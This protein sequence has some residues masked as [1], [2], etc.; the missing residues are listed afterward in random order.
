MFNTISN[1]NR[2]ADKLGNVHFIS[3]LGSVLSRLAYQDDNKFLTNYSKII[4]PI[5]Q[6]KIL[7]GINNVSSTNLSQLLD[8]Q[9]IFKLDKSSNDI[10]SNYE[11][12]FNGK[13]Y[14][15][16]IK[17][18]MPQNV[19]ITNGDISGIMNFPIP[20]EPTAP[21]IVKYISIG[22]SNYGEI[23]IVA[24]KRMPNM[25]FVIFRGTYSSKTASL[26]SKPTSLIPLN[27]CNDST[28]NPET[29]LY[30][31]FK[32]SSEM[33][34]TITESI[35]Y[36][37]TNFLGATQ[38]N[39]VKI[40]TTGHSLGGAMC[41]NF[42][43]LWMGIKKTSPYNT[44]PYNILADNIICISLGAPRCMGKNVSKKF[45]NFASQYKILYLRITTRGD[46]VPALPPKTGFIHPCSD[47][48]QMRQEI[49]EDCNATLTMRP[50]PNINYSQNLDCQNYKTRA[51]I[52]NPLSHTVYLDIMY[53][54]GVDIKKFFTSAVIAKEVL[55]INGDTICRLIM[56]ESPNYKVIF[57][58]VN[59]SR[60]KPTNLDAQFDSELSKVE[61]NN[62]AILQTSISNGGGWF[63]SKPNPKPTPQ[64]STSTII[65]SKYS[66]STLSM[67]KIGGKVAEDVRMTQQ[68]FNSL[69]SQ[70]VNLTGNLCPQ[71]GKIADPFNEQIMPDLSCPGSKFGGKR[72]K[73]KT[74]R[75]K[76]Y[77]KSK[78]S[79]KNKLLS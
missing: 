21:N 69:I 78:K 34:H 57:F 18:Q 79:K 58:N 51:F 17:L 11:V 25:I 67:P 46:P 37:A 30:G 60:L 15:D 61:P 73:R 8:D 63:S 59:K 26:Y 41:T 10:F 13:N 77:K 31:I 54:K 27:V 76:K 19:N 2:K 20:G 7:A 44:A 55:R 48:N 6:P 65:P 47:N 70:M 68:A 40:F 14:I 43:Y 23:Y 66:N 62:N 32:A 39:S 28:G 50:T 9:T 45:C 52:P 5:I 29:F 22:W 38:P 12:Q 75:Q 24:D 42:A 71:Q 33:I 64:T 53:T 36:L 56:G 74:I 4:G 49:S 16:F 3:F 35:T 1:F 72:S